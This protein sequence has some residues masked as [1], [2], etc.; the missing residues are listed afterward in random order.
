MYSKTD[1]VAFYLESRLCSG[2]WKLLQIWPPLKKDI[3][4]FEASSMCSQYGCCKRPKYTQV[5]TYANT[6]VDLL[7][8]RH[9]SEAAALIHIVVASST[10]I[11]DV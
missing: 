5:E 3:I 8:G 4:F 7:G 6:F 10:D 1:A 9:W 2:Q 11:T